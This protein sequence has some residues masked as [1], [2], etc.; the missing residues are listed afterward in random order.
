MPLKMINIQPG[1]NKQATASGAEGQWIDGDN[2]RFRYGLPEKIG[3]WQA[4]VNKKI[5]GAARAQ[6]VFTDLE[7]KEYGAIGTNRVLALYYGGDFYDITPI[8][9]DREV[10]GADI[11]T[12]LGSQTVTIT[13]PSAHDLQPGELTTFSNAGSFS[14]TSFTA[15]DFD[16]V[17]FEVKTVPTAT[18]FTITMPS[19]EATGSVS[20]NGSLDVDPYVN[21]GSDIQT[22]GYGW[23]AGTW[24]ASTWGTARATSSV[25]L[26]PGSWSLDNYGQL[27]IATVQNGR[28]FQWTP[29]AGG[30]SVN[31]RATSISN[32]PTASIMTLVSDRDRHLFHFGT[33]TTIGSPST[34]D[35]L[36]IRFSSQESLTE[37]TPTAINT[38]GTF[39]LDNGTTIVGATQGKDYT[40]VVTDTAAYV[41]Q[42][43]GPP[44]TFSL[45]QV[46]SNCG[47]IGKHAI[48]FVDGTA[49][50]MSEEGGFF[51]YDGTV[52]Y[53]P[54]LVE[55]FVFKTTG[56]NL[57]INYGA[58]D[59]VACGHNSLH[60]EIIW[61]YPKAGSIQIDRMVTYNYAENI[62]YTGSLA[63]TTYFDQSVFA[64]PTATEY[65]STDASN[66]PTVQGLTTDNTSDL[67]QGSTTYYAH[68]IGTDDLDADGNTTAIQAFIR[69]GDY[70]MHADGTDAE[71]LLRVRRFIPDFK[72]LTG[73]A[74]M[75]FIFKNYPSESD[76]T[77]SNVPPTI[78]GPFTINSSTDKVDTR[79]RGRLVSVRIENDDVSQSWRYGTVRLDTQVDG[80]R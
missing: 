42:Y 8:D 22:P 30:G 14:G 5:I 53:M 66:F 41:L 57:G 75:T 38:A 27:L 79:V 63:R 78:T 29:I 77:A 10:N 11:T 40:L 47:L 26:A 31:T 58:S 54:C 7:G 24:G 9:P 34:Q 60:N 35:R 50:W 61:F 76:S 44:F 68:E 52:K 37:Y 62:W 19:A 64:T 18:T 21:P 80:R 32:N 55:D 25:K 56:N 33:E 20:N 74:K 15:T 28:T 1:F 6:H 17:V 65:S 2:V 3:G 45:R 48:T 46:G 13:T 4:L 67:F 16:D 39:R 36:F 49:Y 70:S 69:S 73:D 51:K 23:G 43:V 71:F 72:T 59:I 12:T